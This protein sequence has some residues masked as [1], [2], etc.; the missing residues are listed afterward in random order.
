MALTLSGKNSGARIL[1]L[2]CPDLAAGLEN[3]V[4]EEGPVRHLHVGAFE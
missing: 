2:V 1:L 4:V 3:A